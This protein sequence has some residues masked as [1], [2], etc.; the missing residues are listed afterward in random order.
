[1]S[2]LSVCLMKF[3]LRGGRFAGTVFNMYNRVFDVKKLKGKMYNIA[4]FLI[5]Q[6]LLSF[7][8]IS[9]FNQIPIKK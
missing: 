8:L 9:D 5:S 4:E 7:L 3:C 6:E 1:M 2:Y